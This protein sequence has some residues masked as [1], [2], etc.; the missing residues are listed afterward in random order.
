MH[1]THSRDCTGRTSRRNAPGRTCT[2]RRT[3][4]PDGRTECSCARD[5]RSDPCAPASSSCGASKTCGSRS[6]SAEIGLRDEDFIRATETTNDLFFLF[7]FLACSLLSQ[8]TSNSGVTA[9]SFMA[10]S[11]TWIGR[12]SFKIDFVRQLL[13]RGWHSS[14]IYLLGDDD[15]EF[16]TIINDNRCKRES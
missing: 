9:D 15:D 4:P 14:A 7:F 2:S 13:S 8:S 1:K 11:K 5:S 3:W 12:T 10:N 16:P 6:K